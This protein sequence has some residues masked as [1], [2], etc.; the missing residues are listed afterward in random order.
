MPLCSVIRT[1]VPPKPR[2][3]QRVR[4]DDPR[5]W[6]FLHGQVGQCQHLTG[7]NSP[8]DGGKCVQV[9]LVQPFGHGMG[10]GFDTGAGVSRC[11]SRRQCR[12]YLVRIVLEQGL[13][14]RQIS[15]LFMFIADVVGRKLLVQHQVAGP[16]GSRYFEAFQHVLAGYFSVK[17]D[18]K[19]YEGQTQALGCRQRGDGVFLLHEPRK[20]Y[21][22]ALGCP[23]NNFLQ[24]FRP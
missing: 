3:H 21:G 1:D 13:E 10:N 18:P 7:V 6:A 14:S 12:K 4:D 11:C 9:W 19:L 22:D 17:P 2:I 15:I 5:A 8:G 24:D 20:G 23:S 16:C